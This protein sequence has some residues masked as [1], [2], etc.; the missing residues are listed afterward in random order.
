MTFQTNGRLWVWE[1][2]G[3]V[4]IV[5]DA[6]PVATPVLDISPEVG[7][8]SDHGLL[9]FALHPDFESTGF[10]YL[11]FVVDRHHLL[12]CDSP[13][14]GVPTCFPP[15]SPTTNEYNNATIGRIVRYR[16][17]KPAGEADYKKA[18]A[19][20]YSTR[21]TLVGETSR[22]QPKSTGCP[23][24]YSSHG[25]GTLLFGMDGTLLASCGDG[26]SFSSVDGGSASE[27]YYANALSEGI[28]SQTEN[29]GAFRSQLVNSQNGKVLRLN[30]DTGDGISSNPFFE[31]SAPRSA[32]SRVWALGLR[33]PFRMTLRPLYGSHDPSVGNPGVLYVGDVGWQTWE[34]L[35]VIRA[36]GENLGWPLFE[37]LQAH[38]GYSALN[39]A[40]LEATNP[41]FGGGCNTQYFRFKDL[42]KQ[43]TLNT[44]SWPNPCNAGAQ[45]TTS[46]VFL[47]S[48]PSVDWRHGSASARWAAYDASGNAINPVIGAAAPD[49]TIVNGAQFSGSSS[50]GG[51]WYMGTDFPVEY[52]N[53]YFHGDYSGQ[54]IRNFVF[55]SNN[56]L[57]EVRDFLSGGGGIVGMATHPI[58]GALYYNSW[59]AYVRKI[60]YSP[61]GN[62]PPVAVAT[63]T[64]SYGSSP[65]VV[66]FNAL[67]STDGNNDLLTYQWNFGDGTA[68]STSGN[69]THTY[70][71][72]GGQVKDFS[73]TVTVRDPAGLSS[74]KTLLISV[75]N[76]P[77]SVNITSPVDGSQYSMSGGNIQL[78]LVAQMSDQ[79]SPNSQLTCQWQIILHHNT[80][81]HEEPVINSCSANYT[82]QPVGCDGETYFYSAALTVTDPSGLSNTDESRIYPACGN[83]S[84]PTTANDVGSVAF[85][86][87]VTI[88]VLGND[89]DPDGIVASS[90]RIVAF[91]T[92]GT[93]SSIN[94]T[95][96][97]ITY[98][99]NGALVANDSF[100][101]VVDDSQGAVSAPTPVS[102]SISGTGTNGTVIRVNAGGPQYTDTQGRVWSAD[103]GFNTGSVSTVSNAIAGTADPTLYR[104]T[105]WDSSTSPE[106]G[107]SFAVP[108]G[109]YSVRLHFAETWSGGQGVGLRVFDVFL[110]G[111]LVI[112]NFDIFSEV[113]GY[114]ALI[115]TFPVSVTDGQLNIG[116]AHGSADDPTIAAIEILGVSGGG[117]D[118]QAPTVPQNLTAQAAS[119]TQVNLSWTASTDNGGG[120]VAGYRIYRNG[121][122]IAT[123]TTTAYSNSG[124]TAATQY[125]YRV[126][127]FDNA[128]PANESAQSTAVNVTTQSAG[129]A[130]RVNTGGPQ[131]TDTQGRVWAA[132]FGFNTGQV[133]SVSAAIGGTS[134]PTLYQKDRW[135]PPTIPELSYVFAVPNGSYVVKL[136]FVEHWSGGQGVGL[137]RFDVSIEGNQVL[138]EFDI[139][140]EAGGYTLLVKSFNATVTDGQLNIDFGHGAVDDPVIGAIEVLSVN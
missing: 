121:V 93:I 130:I 115:K 47:H 64:P 79:Q 28:I 98:Q 3:R 20:D 76:T 24:L 104:K 59:T 17:I 69:P 56:V 26:A 50:Q 96:G 101:Y 108:N 66:Q 41:L 125:S 118:T 42:L 83:Y 45:I 135:D 100:S 122:A 30:A 120:V 124:L 81:Q 77:P 75:N 38:A 132:D 37:G 131:Y 139:F 12:N 18:R 110:E 133:T 51:I 39:T 67:A 113:G 138:N 19:I 140:A 55:D 35:H 48:R 117:G 90:V 22:N 16:A 57:R 119:S 74:Q 1:R 71:A 87:S 70:N 49:G 62:V 21:R 112:D 15:Y 102:I 95:T 54:W 4:W 46:D 23:I 68:G 88:D 8:W 116:F 29:V 65:L 82:L 34:D 86:G 6:N 2:G 97:A 89:T 103:F 136:H 7:A 40:N 137:R 58:T 32:R 63:V 72:T 111:A 123:T 31:A 14:V 60:S 105:R 9:G 128:S 53:T 107:Y 114:R 73:A 134:D 36:G 27:T 78:P 126:T 10:I 13:A 129:T 106:L 33:N 80:H 85:G 11:M 92:S 109:S 127:A 44:P 5:D 43:D 61:T 84:P 52:R 25:V 99:H 91:P 94:P